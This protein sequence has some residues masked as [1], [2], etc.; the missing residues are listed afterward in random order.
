MMHA[1]FSWHAPGGVPK[2]KNR[3]ESIR[4][5]ETLR[6]D[7]GVRKALLPHIEQLAV[8]P[9]TVASPAPVAGLG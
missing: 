6:G 4:A 8:A 7:F 1:P 5:A 3:P 2:N 9:G